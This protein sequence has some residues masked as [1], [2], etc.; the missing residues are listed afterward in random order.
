MNRII[1]TGITKEMAVAG[2]LFDLI[3][4]CIMIKRWLVVGA[5]LF[6]CILLVGCGVVQEEYD[7]EQD[8]EQA[9][10][11]SL[12]SSLS[13]AQNDLTEAQNDLTEAQ[14][15]L[16]A[17]Q[18]DLTEAEN[19]I[20]TLESDLADRQGKYVQ[21]LDEFNGLKNQ[22]YALESQLESQLSDYDALVE[23]V[24]KA[25]IYAEMIEKYILVPVFNPT[26]EEKID[27]SWLVQ[28]TG[29]SELKEKWVVVYFSDTN[30]GKEEFFIIVGDALWQVLQWGI[31]RG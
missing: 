4:R 7:V 28:L 26:A 13:E 23:K 20:N 12:Q 1:G 27:L 22:L 19:Q 17:A 10:I 15:D 18:N 31:W 6:I 25:K 24:D 11:A 14:N 21:V 2:A 30:E 29:N 8:I 9:Q 3:R 5:I 16:T